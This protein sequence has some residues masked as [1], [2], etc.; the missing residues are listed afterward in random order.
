VLNKNINLCQ[1]NADLMQIAFV[2]PDVRKAI[3]HWNSIGVGPFLLLPHLELGQVIYQGHKTNPDISLAIA[4]QGN[5]QIEL[6][7][8]HDSVESI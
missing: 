1:H 5:M 8:Q 2:V 7:Q 3:L 6:I 4:Y